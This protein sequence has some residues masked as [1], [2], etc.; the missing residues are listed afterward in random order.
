MATI[1]KLKTVRAKR[2]DPPAYLAEPERQLWRTLRSEYAIEDA[3]GLVLLEQA[4]RSFMRARQ[5]DEQIRREGLL[6]SGKAHPLAAVARDAEKQ[7]AAALR[8]I[9]TRGVAAVG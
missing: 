8:Q 1:A 6:V 5:C 2:I 3:A 4:C 7:A 9:R